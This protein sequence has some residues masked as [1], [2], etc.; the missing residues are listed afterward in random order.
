MATRCAL[1]V[2]LRFISMDRARHLASHPELLHLVRSDSAPLRPLIA[3]CF[4]EDEI[5]RVLEVP[6]EYRTFGSMPI[7]NPLGQLWSGQTPPPHPNRRDQW[8]RQESL[9]SCLN[10]GV[11]LIPR[12]NE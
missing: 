1:E 8:L 4:D 5:K 3:C 2:S 7:R 6:A 12:S 10:F 11:L 9:A